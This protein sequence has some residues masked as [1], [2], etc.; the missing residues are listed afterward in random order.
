MYIGAA[1]RR[2]HDYLLPARLMRCVRAFAARPRTFSRTGYR[3]GEM[4]F[5]GEFAAK[6][7]ARVIADLL[8]LPREDIP[9]FTLLVY[10]VTKAFSLGLSPDET[11]KI[12]N[13]AQ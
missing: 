12:E 8:G 10:E 9:E 1:E 7:P 13:A 3:V 4:D 11:V 2:F 6:L 5:F